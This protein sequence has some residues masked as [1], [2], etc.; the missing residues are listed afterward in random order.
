VPIDGTICPNCPTGALGLPTRISATSSAPRWPQKSRFGEPLGAATRWWRWSA[1]GPP[2][3]CTRFA[4]PGFSCDVAA[5]VRRPRP[6]GAADRGRGR[7]LPRLRAR[8][9]ARGGR[10]HSEATDP[11]ASEET[12]PRGAGSSD[13]SAEVPNQPTRAPGAA[14][15]CISRQLLTN[16]AIERQ[17]LTN[18]AIESSFSRNVRRKGGT[19]PRTSRPGRLAVSVAAE[20]GRLGGRGREEGFS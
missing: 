8:G 3:P 2:A 11:R 9:K 1:V 6:R 5:P 13:P 15:R 18:L 17:L 12:S 16:L 4:D 19:F 20:R 7:G 10:A 14:L